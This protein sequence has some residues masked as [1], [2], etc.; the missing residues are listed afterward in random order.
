MSFFGYHE[1]TGAKRH[2]LYYIENLSRFELG[3]IAFFLTQKADKIIYVFSGSAHLIS[4]P[5]PYCLFREFIYAIH[6][7]TLSAFL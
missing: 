6:C 5:E 2:S 3:L 1:Q 4:L 7:Q